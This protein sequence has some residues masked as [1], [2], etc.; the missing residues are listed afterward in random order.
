MY[1]PG[2]TEEYKVILKNDSL[3]LR[4]GV[5]VGVGVEAR[6]SVHVLIKAH[7]HK[8]VD[9]KKRE[10]K[11]RILGIP[12]AYM[13]HITQLSPLFVQILQQKDDI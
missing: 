3:K 9:R 8:S 12:R 2:I 4:L 1:L 13:S 6:K 7:Q 10:L 11:I 5:G